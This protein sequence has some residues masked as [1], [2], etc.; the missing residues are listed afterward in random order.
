M[1][2]LLIFLKKKF[3]EAR[4]TQ[5]N[6]REEFISFTANQFEKIR[7]KKLRIPLTLYRI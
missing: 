5:L 6:R 4:K 7:K 2:D 1:I 3:L